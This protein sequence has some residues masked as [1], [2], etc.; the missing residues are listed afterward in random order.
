MQ[1]R[2]GFQAYLIHVHLPK[3]MLVVFSRVCLYILLMYFIN[4]TSLLW[5]LSQ[6][7]NLYLVVTTAFPVVA[8]LVYVYIL[9]QQSQVVKAFITNKKFLFIR[10][11]DH[12]QHFKIFKNE[13]RKYYLWIRKFSSLNMLVE[14]HKTNSVSNNQQIF[15]SDTDL[16]VSYK[17]G[18][19]HV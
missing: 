14:H 19:A 8:S 13:E 9:S 15:L 18:R 7:I 1:Q 5:N 12:V 6:V 4:D 16:R 17:I 10:T 3:S 2:T 11:G